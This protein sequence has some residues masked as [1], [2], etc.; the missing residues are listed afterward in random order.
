MKKRFCIV[1]H[2]EMT[3]WYTEE[4][5]GYEFFR[6]PYCGNVFPFHPSEVQDLNED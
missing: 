4:G 5:S 3:Y 2:N 6:C 1:C